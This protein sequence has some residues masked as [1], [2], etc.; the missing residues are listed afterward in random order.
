[1]MIIRDLSYS[2]RRLRNSPGF[3][4]TAVLTL[5]L[6][7]GV[8]TAV[9]SVIQAVLLNSLPF[10]HPEQLYVFRES[11]KA[12]AMSVAWPNFEE[13]RAQQH[14]FEGLAA[15]DL[16]HFDYFDGTHTSLPR[17]ARVTAEFFPLLGARPFLGRLFSANEDKPGAP[18]VVMLSHSFWQN[19]LHGDSKIVGSS[20][21]VSGKP[22][23]IVGVMPPE[24][25]FFLSRPEDMYVPLGPEAADPSFNNRTAHG[26]I[27]V[28][29]RPRPGVTENAARAELEGIAAR[30]AAEYPATNGDHSVLM[31]RLQENYFKSIRPVLS[32]L[33]AAVA[34]V[35]LVGCANVSN[36]LLTRSADREREYA[37]RAALG[38]SGYRIF[39][40]SLGE[41]LW[42]AVF[43]GASGVLIAYASLPFLL[44]LGPQDIPRLGDTAIRWPVLTFSFAVTAAIAIVCSVLPGWAT[45]R[46]APEQALRSHSVSAYAGHRRQVI[47]S[48]LLVAGVAVT[49]VLVAGTGLL[50]QS[51]RKTLAVNPGFVPEHLL[52]L[53]IVLT[54]EKY[55]AQQ[56]SQSFFSTAV[57]RLRAVAG[58]IDVGNVCT[59]PL[60]GECGDYFYTIPGRIQP[61]DPNLPIALHNVADENY[62]RAAGIRT[63]SGRTF[64][65]TDNASSAHVTVVNQTFARK[66]WP[67]GDA[68]GHMLRFGGRGEAGDLLQIVGVVDDVKQFGFDA[69]TEPEMFVPEAQGQHST[70]VL[71][72]RTS[73]NPESIAAAAETAIHTIDKEVPVRIHPMS[74][75]LS[76]SLRQRQF[77]TLLLSIFAGLAL[78]LAALGV[79]G[80]AAYAVASRKAEIA[81]RIALGAQPQS[82]K[83]WITAQIVRKVALGCL[84]GLLGALLSTRLVRDLLYGVSPTDPFV[85]GATCVL[86]ITGALPAAWIPAR[87]AASIDPMQTLRA[88]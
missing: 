17:A 1:M 46:I 48:S 8:T 53:D 23:S 85:L 10:P 32:L 3:A 21:N 35:L 81:V 65:S 15:Y 5:A 28:L 14:S 42:L 41:S 24:F 39:Q 38:A 77:L 80:V 69:E 83:R 9:Y 86:L 26:S 19:Q 51:L 33:M 79:F 87:R 22:Y 29:A 52:S 2:L 62:F 54:G 76:Q 12:Q 56:A 31:Y 37:V 57:D 34:I 66:W 49:I 71:L 36:L 78:F 64:L 6:G 68:V 70:M 50:L 11:A 67:T 88:E 18:A 4:L 75:Y 59:P 74:Y 61:D 30:I 25:H 45:L 58:V 13:W 84:V 47:R 20:V 72:V 55:K 63:I 40:Q 16:K 44:R 60:V 73:G 27:S 82:V 7:M 43:A